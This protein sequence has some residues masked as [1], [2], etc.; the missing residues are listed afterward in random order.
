MNST[1]VLIEIMKKK[2]RKKSRAVWVK[3]WLK[4]IEGNGVCRSSIVDD[5]YRFSGNS[6]L[7]TLCKKFP[8]LVCLSYLCYIETFYF[9]VLWRLFCWYFW[10]WSYLTYKG[11]KICLLDF[12]CPQFYYTALSLWHPVKASL[13]FLKS[14]ARYLYT[15]SIFGIILIFILPW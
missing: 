4:Q 9:Q 6:T 2:K 1:L 13:T 14:K 11:L 15:F 12:S 7:Q 3:D 5:R 8:W 10:C